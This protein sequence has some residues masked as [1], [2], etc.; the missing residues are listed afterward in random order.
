MYFLGWILLSSGFTPSGYTAGT[1]GTLSGY[2][3][4]LFR[5]KN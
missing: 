2:A 5:R 4:L 3:G 1:T